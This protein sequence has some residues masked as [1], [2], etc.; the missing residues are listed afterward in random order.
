M[1]RILMV[2]DEAI[3]VKGMLSVME[4]SGLDAEVYSALSGPEALEILSQKR[5]D[6]VV[7]DMAMPGM[8]GLE[9]MRH[10]HA[11]WPECRVIFLSGHS[12]F[13]MIYQAIQGEAVTF[14]LKTEGFDRIIA[15]IRDTMEKMERQE[16][17]QALEGE[18]IRQQKFTRLLLRR[19]A[20]T[21]FLQGRSMVLSP[22]DPDGNPG[23][24]PDGDIE[25][26]MK[27]PVL[28]L[29]AYWDGGTLG[30][31]LT[32]FHEKLLTMDRIFR[33]YLCTYPIRMTFWNHH[34]D[35][36]WLLQPSGELEGN[37]CHLYVREHMELIQRA[38]ERETGAILDFA[39]HPSM[40]DMQELPG[41][42]QELRC[43][44]CQGV[45]VPGMIALQ[46]E[47]QRPAASASLLP[48]SLI[49][50]LRSAMEH[51]NR[52]EMEK[53]LADATGILGQC[54]DMDDPYAQEAFMRLSG[55][56]LAYINRWKLHGKVQFPGGLA[57][58]TSSRGFSSWRQAA[59]AFMDL[60]H[61]LISLHEGD[62]GNRSAAIVYQIRD[63]MAR[64]LASPDEVTL[65]R[66]AE[67]TYFNPAYLSRLYHQVTGETLSDTLSRLRVEK[68][69]DMLAGGECRIGDIAQALGF[70]SSA[71]FTRFYRKMTGKA[72]QEYRDQLAR[73]SLDT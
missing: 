30:L 24:D 32:E 41:V 51:M 56:F 72:P 44:I 23:A 37:R 17:N 33:S 35:I 47:R 29:Y 45:G 7:S 63:H 54:R 55:I 6:I 40:I 38:V 13:D 2:D 10:I 34:E 22:V 70:S 4:K 39:L 3:I 16:R 26:N 60:G 68:A 61:L 65:S 50:R 36:L 62:E 28:P 1:R 67:I 42:Y 15:T 69:N 71:N 59:D 21:S 18:L 11:Q 5:M 64:H 66:L 8:D 52:T 49:G 12:E 25:I 73:S 46:P 57:G 14:L 58:L 43:R 53:L 9:L 20:L 31:G 27:A 48:D 19:E